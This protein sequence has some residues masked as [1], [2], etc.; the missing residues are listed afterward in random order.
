MC[1]CGNQ[2]KGHIAKGSLTLW[3]GLALQSTG[4]IES[5]SVNIPGFLDGPFSIPTCQSL[6]EAIQ[7]I[8][9][10]DLERLVYP[11]SLYE[12]PISWGAVYGE[13][14]IEFPNHLRGLVFWKLLE[15]L[16]LTDLV[17]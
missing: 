4:Y 12:L 11:Y 17:G 6:P 1:A 16:V 5:V 9:G 2:I 3:K 7:C 13:L 14:R 8:G 10:S 15:G